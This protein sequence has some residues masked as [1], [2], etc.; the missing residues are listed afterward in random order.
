MMQNHA[1]TNKRLV[2]AIQ[3]AA[4]FTN[5]SVSANTRYGMANKVAQA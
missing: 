4:G 1:N 3:R 2:A 5:N